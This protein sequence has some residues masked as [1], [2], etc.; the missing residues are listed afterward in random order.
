MK[1]HMWLVP[2]MAGAATLPAPAQTVVLK[3]RASAASTVS[4]TTRGT[5]VYAAVTGANADARTVFRDLGLK[6]KVK[7]LLAPTAAGV[8]RQPVESQPLEAAIRA[9]AAASGLVVRKIV[10]PVAAANALTAETAEPLASAL[11]DTAASAT[12]VDPAT[13]RAVTLTYAA[14][15]P[16]PEAGMAAVYYVLRAPR[17]GAATAATG[18][19]ARDAIANAAA[20]FSDLPMSQR[21]QAMR[22]LQQ[23]MF[24]SMT[25]EEREQ[26]RQQGP[27]RGP[28]GPG[29][30]G[31][32][33]G[34]PPGAPTQ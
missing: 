17:R 8:V 5:D 16:K 14:T 1:T 2:I 27:G 15:A 11:S 31:G 29:G 12:V 32:Y 25:P 9:T 33:G 19:A 6:S 10:L 20:S 13:G 22:E 4:V 23:R 26:M 21:M 28:G 3:P 24:Q 30:M 34:P 18:D 7:I